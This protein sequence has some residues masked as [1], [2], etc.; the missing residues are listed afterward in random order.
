MHL[1]ILVHQLGE[2]ADLV[3][4]YIKLL[5]IYE[6]IR[7][8][9]MLGWLPL[10]SLDKLTVEKNEVHDKIIQLL[11]PWNMVKDNNELG[12]KTDRLQ[13]HINR[14]KDSECALKENLLSSSHR[15]Q[16][17]ENKT[18]TLIIRSLNYKENSS[19]SLR[20]CQQVKSGHY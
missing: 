19:A 17:V 4:L 9:L 7:K 5:T 18:E 8:I 10:A 11:A 3:I 15:A 16:I 2:G 14:A 1:I 6:K 13:M 12:D 20:G